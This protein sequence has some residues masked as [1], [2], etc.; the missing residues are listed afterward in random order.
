MSNEVSHK[1]S[2]NL[3]SFFGDTFS[4]DNERFL[5][6][7]KAYYE[8][9]Q[10]T[11]VT[12]TGVSGTFSRDELIVGSSTRSIAKIKEVKSGSLVVQM[13]SKSVFEKSETITGQTSS[14]T[15]T[16]YSVKDNIIRS[17]GKLLDNRT[18]DNSV[19]KYFEYLHDELYSSIPLNLY[20]D[21]RLVAN[22]FK[23]FFQSKS[24]EQSYRFLFRLLY[25]EEIEFY[26]PGE[27][28]LRVSD[29]NYE[30]T[31]IIRT[32][33]VAYGIDS[34]GNSYEIDIFNFLN[35]TIRG[36]TSGTL[37]N[38]IDI[39]KFYVGSQEI[40]EMT[41]TLVSGEFERD[42]TIVD[43]DDDN[44]TTTVFGIVSR[45]N[46]V[47]GGSGYQVGD[48][49]SI[50]GDGSQAQATVSS[51]K[52]SP[53]TALKVNS[54]GY[55]YRVNT[56]A[57]IDNTATG[58]TGLVVRVSEISEPY[59]VTSGPNTYELGKISKLS[60]INRGEGYFKSPSI[61]LEDTVISSLGL[62]TDKL[63]TIQNSGSNYGVGNTLVFS[64]G[65]G[66]NAAGIIASVEE[67]V[68]Y[69]FLF[70][71]DQRMI[72]DGSYEDILKNEEWNVL[73]PI[74]RIE[75]TNFGTGYTNEN[76]PT[77]TI[78][79]TTGNNANLIVNGIQGT[80]A[81]I[82]VD[83]ANNET[84]IGSIRAITVLNF[85]IDYSSANA[86][87][88]SVGDGNANVTPVISG[89]GI[90]DGNW[91]NDE[92]KIDYKYIQDSRFY[93]DFSYVIKSGLGYSFYK[94]SIKKALHPAGLQFFGEILIK[95]FIDITPRM[96]VEIETLRSIERYLIY[97]LSEFSVEA[98][99]S[100][101]LRTTLFVIPS[102]LSLTSDVSEVFE[103]KF[104]TTNTDS[105]LDIFKETNI[106]VNSIKN[107]EVQANSTLNPFI[108]SF[109]LLDLNSPY[110][111]VN[112]YQKISG[113]ASYVAG[114]TYGNLTIQDVE[115]TQ[116]QSIAAATFDEV[117]SLTVGTGTTFAVDF[118]V[119]DVFLA[120]NEYFTARLVL[121]NTNMVADRPPESPYTNV[122]IYK[123]V[124]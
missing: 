122:P 123:I 48:V 41:V 55:G 22:N 86:N 83:V 12:L 58:G 81:D 108:E 9:L 115:T 63:I 6:F 85:G 118:G 109:A 60:I 87:T 105:V 35:K 119:G 45:F 56:P 62:L 53:I 11:T 75:L 68:S 107:I 47:D 89:L 50:T 52:E 70:E 117:I 15:G 16:V 36:Q 112:K 13:N 32:Q 26:Y 97:I 91:T 110:E 39:K 10:T 102:A 59:T 103:K 38:V 23:K 90:K 93:Q 51:I 24:N 42:E 7:L 57:I 82:Q 96:S 71:D 120:N 92:G 72:L 17:S 8:W 33:S 76:L 104:F 95:D 28:L 124:P 34:E 88:S 61:T 1:P 4:Q 64:G 98:T 37:A 116:I 111:E 77:I 101:D 100:T 78:N 27:D 84:G 30:K 49:I 106:E 18:I 14:A 65:S 79:S 80:S 121:S 3:D 114:S 69:D 5:V 44:L 29:G 46:I 54:I 21:K 73:G 99:I 19:D 25:D 40:A 67:T 20:G 74:S 113:T 31:N 66:A 2:L 94:D 43:I